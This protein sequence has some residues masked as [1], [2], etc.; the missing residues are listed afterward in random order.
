MGGTSRSELEHNWEL[1]EEPEI[2]IVLGP[3]LIAV[4]E[5]SRYAKKRYYSR[6][7][8]SRLIARPNEQESILS[9]YIHLW[10]GRKHP[11]HLE[12]NGK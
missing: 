9:W 11:S 12:G 2:L 7:F 6:Y 8:P 3:H 1:S 10:L 4:R 5:N